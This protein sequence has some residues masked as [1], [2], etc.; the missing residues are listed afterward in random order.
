MHV[1]LHVHGPP[2]FVTQHVDLMTKTTTCVGILLCYMVYI[3]RICVQYV[4]EL[5]WQACVNIIH[6]L[7]PHGV[8]IIHD[9]SVWSLVR[10][11]VVGIP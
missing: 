8:Y 5:Y 10:I 3:D 2:S 9:L 7:L 6:Y 1:S 4:G 11:L